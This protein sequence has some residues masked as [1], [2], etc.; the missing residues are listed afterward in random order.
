MSEAE[1]SPEQWE[2]EHSE[3]LADYEIFRVRRERLRSPRDGTSHDF[4]IVDSEDGVT[5]IALT[6]D[7]EMVLVEQVRHPLGRVTLETPSGFIDEGEEAIE[8][9]LRELREETGYLAEDPELI[10]RL[11]INPSWQNTEVS[12]VLV[13]NAR[14][15]AEKELDAGEDTRVHTVPVEEVRSMLMDGRIFSSSIVAALGLYFLGNGRSDTT[16]AGR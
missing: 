3:Q 11:V 8:A 12:V 9:G 6:P 2:H 13:R 5:V 7:D 15:E 14:R 1:S 10:G 4:Y 16:T